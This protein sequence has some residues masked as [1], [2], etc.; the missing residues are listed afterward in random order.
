MICLSVGLMTVFSAISQTNWYKIPQFAVPLAVVSEN[1]GFSCLN[2]SLGS[3]GNKYTLFKSIDGMCSYTVIKSNYGDLGGV[4]LAEL[5]FCNDTLGF[6]AESDK[7]F[8]S[9][10]RTLDGG[11]HWQ[12]I[13]GDGNVS[14]FKI[15]FLNKN[16]G[17]YCFYPEGSN[18]SYLRK[19][20]NGI[21]RPILETHQYLFKQPVIFFKSDVL[22]F[23]LCDDSLGGHVI[24]RTQDSGL[25]WME[26]LRDSLNK[27]RDFC[28]IN[29]TMAIT[30]GDNATIYISYDQGS[31]WKKIQLPWTQHLNSVYFY[32]DSLGYVAGNNG[33]LIS[34]KIS[35]LG[36]DY[37][38]VEFP[39]E[40]NL[41]YVRVFGE[42]KCFVIETDGSLYRNFS[43]QG[44]V[45]IN[46][47]YFNIFPNPVN[48]IL[49][50]EPRNHVVEFE[51]KLIS[52]LGREILLGNNIRKIDF[53]NYSSGVYFI[54][55]MGKGTFAV[56]KILKQ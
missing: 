50:I 11:G 46:T 9:F 10:F 7:G 5:F 37:H 34:M 15:F 31:A 56:K 25:S 43:P 30:I 52:C 23:I 13:S 29:D 4:Y 36:L 47:D 8:P 20:E 38:S 3:H 42:N 35:S 28:F 6:I 21:I 51:I 26:V 39:S 19:Y 2:E 48:D 32:R 16:L 40:K 24:L 49:F 33:L 17:Y 1:I 22:G 45:N 18:Y 54:L 44:T 41:K 12:N 27:F 53:T 14:N 55:F